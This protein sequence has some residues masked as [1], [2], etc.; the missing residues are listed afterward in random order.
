M[1]RARFARE[2]H[3]GAFI[4]DRGGNAIGCVARQSGTQ[5]PVVNA[6]LGR[7]QKLLRE[8]VLKL[9]ELMQAMKSFEVDADG[10]SVHFRHGGALPA[11]DGHRRGIR[12]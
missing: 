9:R 3:D 2:L 4:A 5:A 7:I 12:E 1:E 6:E 8:E 11:G 10:F